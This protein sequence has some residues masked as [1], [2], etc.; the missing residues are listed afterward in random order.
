MTRTLYLHIGSGK[1]G[2]TTIQHH[3]ASL[4]DP[5]L[6]VLPLRSFGTPNALR[7]VAACAGPRARPFFVDSRKIMT[8]EE[9]INNAY[10][11]WVRTTQEVEAA[12]VTRF[13]SSSEFL[14]HKVRGRDIKVMHTH[15][16]GI[17]DRIKIIVYLREQ[18]SFLRSLWAQ[19]V[20]GPT[21]SHLTF[22]EFIE[23]LEGRHAHWDYRRLLSKWM[24]VFGADAVEACVFDPE[25]FDGGD[26]LTDF[27][28]RIGAAYRPDP[29]VGAPKENVTPMAKELD[30]IR[31]ENHVDLARR[32]G[33]EPP[34]RPRSGDMDPEAYDARVL[35]VVSDSNAWVNE[36]LLADAKVKLPVRAG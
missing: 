20:K 29:G 19:S 34:A 22:A 1:A 2:S 14:I 13:V 7:L 30:R 35:D 8:S 26:L 16:T 5:A 9:F 25:A 18:K 21:R 32:L 4:K 11:L 31:Y 27:N 6:G 10:S 15:M 12:P 33:V 17:F 24:E 23:T 3:V 36:T 28:T